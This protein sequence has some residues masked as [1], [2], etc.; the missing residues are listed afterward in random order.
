MLSSLYCVH[1]LIH[2]ADTNACERAENVIMES[3][4]VENPEGDIQRDETAICNSKHGSLSDLSEDDTEDTSCEFF[5]GVKVPESV[6]PLNEVRYIK[7]FDVIYN[8]LIINPMFPK[9]LLT[10]YYELCCSQNTFLNEHLLEGLY[11][12]L[13]AGIIS[14]T[15]NIADAIKASK[16]IT[17][18]NSF[19]TWDKT[20]QACEMFGMNV[21]FL[22]T[23]L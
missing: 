8:G 23:S 17:V 18:E 21:G 2:A 9:P 10:K 11:Q 7:N 22:F 16:I 3:M 13:V 14:E 1:N 4:L 6:V 19:S 20:L 15:T 5:E 12:K